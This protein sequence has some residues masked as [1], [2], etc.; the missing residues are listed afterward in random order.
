MKPRD[1]IGQ[2]PREEIVK[3]I[4]AAERRTSGEIR[5]FISRHVVK[6]PVAAAAQHFCKL[7]MEKTRL[8]NGVMIFVAPKSHTFAV[9]GDA[10]I[11]ER[12]GQAFWQGLVQDVG[13]FFGRL[14][15]GPGLIHAIDRVGE[16]L[17]Q[18]FPATRGDNPNELPDDVA[19]D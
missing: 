15:F 6:D 5:V 2:L 19:H 4:Q 9:I 17:A 14:E 16:L 10:G 1:F 18:H 13:N 7:G 8:R 12:C 11:H 3:A